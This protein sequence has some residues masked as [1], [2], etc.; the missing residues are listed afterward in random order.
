MKEIE[1]SMNSYASPVSSTFKN[2]ANETRFNFSINENLLIRSNPATPELNGK[3]T[4]HGDY[5][6]SPEVSN[7]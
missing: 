2:A 1:L 4:K 3:Y 7:L 5:G 6:P